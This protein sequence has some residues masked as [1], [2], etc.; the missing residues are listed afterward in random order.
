VS[1]GFL[2]TDVG[3]YRIALGY[4]LERD[5][6]P[7]S[8]NAEGLDVLLSKAQALLH[9]GRD[10]DAAAAGDAALAMIA[11]N[12]ALAPYRLLALD[13]AAVDNLAAGHFARALELYDKEMPLVDALRTPSAE[14][15]R[16]VARFSRA[17]AA[18][19]ARE[20]SRALADLD[21]VDKLLAT[22]RRSRRSSGRTRPPVTWPAR[23]GSSRAACARTRAGSS[24]AWTTKRRPS[25]RGTRSS[26]S[27]SGRRIGPRS[28]ASRCSRRRS[29]R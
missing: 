20:P 2:H 15:N 28:S 21:Y 8:D 22:Q 11:R 19:G 23:T 25:A 17:A 29:S 7:Y 10:G 5:K 12:P 26:R 4:L 6:L 9:V 13:W 14:R 27:D 24:V 16:I 1:S 3:N 18:V